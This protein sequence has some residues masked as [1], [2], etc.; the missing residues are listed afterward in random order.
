MERSLDAGI[1]RGY[2]C[3]S[4][5]SGACA[6]AGERFAETFAKWATGDIG[7][8]LDVGYKVLPPALP[9]TAWGEPLTRLGR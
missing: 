8:N 5:V 6:Q 2:G 1:P 9:L 3:D 4:G 7:F